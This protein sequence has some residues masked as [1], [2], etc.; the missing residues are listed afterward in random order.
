[1]IGVVHRH[2]AL[3]LAFILLLVAALT[4]SVL[5]Y[6][7]AFTPVAWVTV[8]ADHTGLQLSQGADVELRGVLVGQVR[9]IS[10][11]GDRATL[12]L[13]LDPSSLRR[14]PADVTVQL[15]PKS[16]FGERYVSLTAPARPSAGTL[17]AGAVIGQD[18]S[19]SA[20]ELE[21]VLDDTLPLL[22]AI[23]PD[24]LAATLGAI[25]TALQG[26][27]EEIGDDLAQ[28]DRYLSALNGQLPALRADLSKLGTVLSTYD[29]ALPDLLDILRNVTVTATTISQQRE[30]LA[31]FLDDATDLAGSA[32]SFLQRYGDR[33]IQVGQVSAPLLQLLA[34]YSPEYPCLLQGAVK[35]QPDVEKVFAGGEMHITLEIT[36]SNGKYEPGRDAPV[37]GADD[38]PDCRGL[39]NP[40]VPAPQV[41][42]DDGYDYSGSRLAAKLPV[43]LNLA[44]MGYA[45]TPEEQALIKPLVAAATG[46]SPDEVPPVADLLWGPLLRGTVVN[47]Q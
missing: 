36:R 47:G 38:G 2:R 34:T 7:K 30:Q 42:L 40:R 11:D 19:S 18:R 13:A 45:G 12:R 21:R 16:L 9:G 29:G 27:G 41:T 32:Q 35:Q 8:H 46:T 31:A 23:Q 4:M 3:G 17:R 39:P 37:Y 43:S 33:I 14:I 44:P 22:R 10:S 5:A 26:K 28:L 6:R 1:V 24:K 15:L 20:I 25:A